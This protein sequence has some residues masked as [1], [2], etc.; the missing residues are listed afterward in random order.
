MKK[1]LLIPVLVLI[2]TACKDYNGEIKRIPVAKAGDEV[3]YYDQIPRIVQPGTSI[4]DSTAIIRSY[5]NN[6]IKKELVYAKAE[7]NLTAEHKSEINRQLEE[8][9]A[10]LLIYHYHRQM[11]VQ[12]MDT[13]VSENEIFSYFTNNEESFMLT[14]NI[15]KALYIKIPLEA[16]NID[17][18]RQWVKSSDNSDLNQLESYCYQFAVKFDDSDEEWIAFNLLQR[19]LPDYIDN[20][21]NFLRRNEFYETTD[22]NFIYFVHLRDYRL[23]NSLAPIDYVRSEIKSIILNNRRIEFLEKLESGIYNEAVKAGTFKIY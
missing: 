13:V 5:V 7:D 21:E 8:T 15:V 17:K 10:N 22:D 20:Q 11:M 12:K 4:A 2:I 23:R 9:R 16:P 6:W 19:E 3:L 18:V 1:L 14:T